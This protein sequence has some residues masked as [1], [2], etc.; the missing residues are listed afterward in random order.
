MKDTQYFSFG[1]HAV[2]KIGFNRFENL[3]RAF[4]GTHDNFFNL[5]LRGMTHVVALRLEWMPEVPPVS[6]IEELMDYLRGISYF[7]EVY[8]AEALALWTAAQDIQDIQDIPLND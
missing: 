4:A 1:R 3:V 6:E 2:E 7:K 5:Q 8:G